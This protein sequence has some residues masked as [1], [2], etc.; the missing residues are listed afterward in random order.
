VRQVHPYEQIAY[1]FV[2]VQTDS[3]A[4]GFGFWGSYSE[5]LSFDL[6]ADKVKNTF[7]VKTFRLTGEKKPIRL[8]GFMPGS[9]KQALKEALRRG[10]DVF[11]TGEIDYHTAVFACMKGCLVVELGH[12]QS[13]VFFYPVLSAWFQ[14]WG[15]SSYWVDGHRQELI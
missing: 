2:S 7:K 4:S 10:C 12:T 15:L 13:E 6:F 11:I 1:Q 3:G 8:V 9:G 14:E 5:P